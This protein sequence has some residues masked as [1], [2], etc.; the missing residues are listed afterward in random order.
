MVVLIGPSCFQH[1]LCNVETD[2]RAMDCVRHLQGGLQV[3]VSCP[4]IPPHVY[5]GSDLS[6]RCVWPGSATLMGRKPERRGFLREAQ[7]PARPATVDRDS[8]Q[9]GVEDSDCFLRLMV[10]R[11][12]VPRGPNATQ[13][14]SKKEDVDG[15]ATPEYG[16]PRSKSRRRWRLN[17]QTE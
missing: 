2:N 5:H 3:N 16:C 13:R 1:T 10:C 9:D 12:R 17:D 4:T 15:M 11:P 6:D 8:R 14:R 7:G